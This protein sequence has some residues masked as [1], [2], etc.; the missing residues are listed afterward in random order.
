MLVH[1]ASLLLLSFAVSLDGFGVGMTYGLRKIR[2]P[3]PSILIISVC[4]G[5]ILLLSMMAGVALAGVLSPHG[6]SAVGAVILIGIGVWALVQFSRNRDRDD[7]DA[8]KEADRTV[9]PPAKS[10]LVTLEIRRLGII[11][12]ILRTPSAADVD[13][14]GI[15]TAGGGFLLGAA[16]S[17]DAFGAGIGAAL[18][19]FPPV[20]TAILIACSS[21]L[22]LWLGMRFG[23][24]AAGWRWI[25]KLSVLPGIIL[26]VMGIVKLF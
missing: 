24:A 1:G 6:A 11:I 8:P 2:I 9:P 16:L 10:T 23:F 18:V 7:A 15:I 21:G 12:Q 22:F 20:A 13:R 17:L 26:I 19:G 4:S 14:S 3:L 5:V 25:R